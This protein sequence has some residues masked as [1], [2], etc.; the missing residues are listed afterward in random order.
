MYG[1]TPTGRS[2]SY[3]YYQT[4]TKLEGKKIYIPCDAINTQIPE[5]LKGI[6]INPALISPIRVIYESEITDF[7]RAD[8]EIKREELRRR[9][10]QLR[11]EETRL[12][13]LFIT[14]NLSESSYKHLREEWREKFHH[15]EVNL[16]DLDRNLARY[17]DDL[18]MALF[19][20][21]KASDLFPRLEEVKKTNLLQIIVKRFIVNPIGEIIDFELNTPFSY[22]I[23]L[24]DNAHHINSTEVCGSEHVRLG[25]PGLVPLRF[26]HF[27]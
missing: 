15:A 12:G 26:L 22:L 20:L 23:N 8:R 21:T 4:H 19:L 7:S 24:M 16:K 5:W 25:S 18:D 17:I 27:A 14:G 6:N 1:S 2:Q 11:E 13:R 3:M 9:L 10:T